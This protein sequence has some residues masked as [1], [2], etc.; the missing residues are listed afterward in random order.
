MY[1]NFAGG[2]LDYVAL[3]YRSFRHCISFSS[4]IPCA[5]RMHINFTLYIGLFLDSV[6]TPAVLFVQA[7]ICH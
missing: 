5:L 1:H 7:F 6:D 4:D 3:L 2:S